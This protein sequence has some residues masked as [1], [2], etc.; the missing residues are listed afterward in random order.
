MRPYKKIWIVLLTA[1]LF[2]GCATMPSPETMNQKIAYAK[3]TATG[4]N[5]SVVQLLN[6]DIITLDDAIR[7]RDMVRRV[8]TLLDAAGNY[9]VLG[10]QALAASSWTDANQMLLEING[11]LVERAQKE[12]R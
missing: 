2:A 12:A 11:I 8:R 6:A 3:A 7:Y 9:T 4:I 1:A 10:E 5:T